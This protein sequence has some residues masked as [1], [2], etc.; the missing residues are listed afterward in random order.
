MRETYINFSLLKRTNFDIMRTDIE[1]LHKCNEC[2]KNNKIYWC[3][4]NRKLLV[5]YLDY[6]IYIDIL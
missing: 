1:T 2:G 6:L 5:I 4:E 3:E